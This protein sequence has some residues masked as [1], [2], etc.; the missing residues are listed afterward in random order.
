MILN[1]VSYFRFPHQFKFITLLICL[2]SRLPDSV[3]QLDSLFMYR[4]LLLAADT[5]PVDIIVH[6]PLVCEDSAIPYCFLPSK[7]VHIHSKHFSCCPCVYFLYCAS[8]PRLAGARPRVREQTLHVC[9][10]DPAS[11]RRRLHARPARARRRR[12]RQVHEHLRALPRARRRARAR[13]HV[14]RTGTRRP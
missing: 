6:L 10:H 1:K 4:I 11:H 2:V 7:K 12:T 8:C 14:R 9:A 5:S 13:A 3:L